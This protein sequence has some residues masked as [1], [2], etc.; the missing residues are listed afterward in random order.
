MQLKT[1]L[2]FLQIKK[3]LSPSK[4][5]KHVLER[6]LSKAWD[7]QYKTVPWYRVRVLY[8]GS[9]LVALVII[10]IGGGATYAYTSPEVTEGTV[11]YPVK[12][13]MERVEEATKFTP[14]AKAKFILKTIER[15]E[16]EKEELKKIFAKNLRRL[17]KEILN[18]T[19]TPKDN[20]DSPSSTDIDIETTTAEIGDDGGVNS[21]LEKTE[22][23]LEKAEDQLEK[24]NETIKRFD[25]QENELRPEVRSKIQDRL[26]KRKQRLEKVSEFIKNKVDQPAERID[27]DEKEDALE[28]GKSNTDEAKIH[29]QSRRDRVED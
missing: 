22:Q 8:V 13:A 3:Q 23:S 11:L 5:F 24:F 15:R 10:L 7:E 2:K 17:H 12:K 19:D 4:D 14:E 26:E 20:Q 16:A 27:E 6:K 9:A 28:E 1:R 18:T 29:I 21:N 25:S